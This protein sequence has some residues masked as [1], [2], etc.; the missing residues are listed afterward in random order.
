MSIN[1]PMLSA[2]HAKGILKPP[3]LD[4]A[5]KL[6]PQKQLIE[7]AVAIDDKLLR[8]LDDW[9][10]FLEHMAQGRPLTLSLTMKPKHRNEQHE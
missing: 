6:E 4:E 10:S 1:T 3:R 9:L 2:V 7:F 5:E 8:P